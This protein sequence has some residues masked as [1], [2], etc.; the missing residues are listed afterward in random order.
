[1][2]RFFFV[3]LAAFALGG[4][5]SFLPTYD[6]A[7]YKRLETAVTEIEKIGGALTPDYTP[8]PPYATF[9]PYYIS[10]LGNLRAA[11]ELAAGRSLGYRGSLSARSASLVEQAI[12]NCRSAVDRMRVHHQ[13]HGLTRVVFENASVTET[14]SI[15]KMMEA[16]L[17]R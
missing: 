4:C 16:R 2:R 9:E 13:A 8:Q 14:C 17:K 3:L 6:E 7:L 10:A 15:P 12:H 11:E 5:V 1:M